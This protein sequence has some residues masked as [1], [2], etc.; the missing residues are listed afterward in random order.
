MEST[1]LFGNGINLLGGGKT[2]NKILMDISDKAFLPPIHS[3]T[4]KYEY[5]ILPQDEMAHAKLMTADGHLLTTSDGKI[6]RVTVNTEDSLKRELC[7]K[8]KEGKPSYFYKMLTELN[9]NHYITT[10]YELFL[11]NSFIENGFVLKI[12]DQESRLYKHELF[13]SNNRSVDVWNIHGDINN[14]KSIM[15]GLSD[16]CKYVAEID[17]YLNLEED[18][19][20]QS[21]IDL[22]FNT[23]VHIVGLGMAYEEIDLWNVLTTRMRMKR[24]DENS[25]KNKIYYYAIQDELF[26]TGK[27]KLL[28]AM[29][30]EVVD[31]SF[32]WSDEAYKKAYNDIYEILLKIIMK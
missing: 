6:L 19:K 9:V 15:L 24:K 5:I 1:I 13:E 20:G 28:E 29:G 26:D 17:R 32:D 30:V 7:H 11:N 22:L 25:C 12:N 21:W 31:I 4:L 10:N 18:K 27:K 8:L 23:D 16:Y 14:E 2:W 3:N